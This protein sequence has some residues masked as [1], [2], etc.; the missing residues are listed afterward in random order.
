MKIDVL[1]NQVDDHN[2][3][4]ILATQKFNPN[5]V[6][7]I[8]SNE[9]ES[10][11]KSLREYYKNNFPKV[12]FKEVSVNEADDSKLKNIL[13]EHKSKKIIVNLTGGKRINSLILCNLCITNDIK[14]VYV[15]ILNKTLYT[16]DKDIEVL[17]EEFDDLEIEDVINASGGKIINHATT[18]CEKED[19]IYLTKCIY[20]NL[21]LW[22]NHKQKLY[23]ANIFYHDYGN[24]SRVV[25]KTKALDIKDKKMIEAILKKL[26][27]LNGIKY[28]S[29]EDE[30]IEVNF[31]NEY[32]KAFIFKSGTWLEMAT[33]IMIN[34]IKDVDEVKSGVIFLWN[35]DIRMIRNEVDVVAIKDS[36][37]ICISC[38]DSDK[39]N[40]TALN[41]LNVY[42]EKIGGEKVHKILVA[43]K[44]PIK[45]S[46]KE[47]AKEMNIHLIIFDGDEN[48]FKKHI[49]NIIK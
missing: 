31:L 21:P 17:K 20:K 3:G 27:E 42:S 36:V 34:E 26:K 40:E 44:E 49:Q 12:I 32:L 43:T 18:L 47:R 1:I 6:V 25:I 33:N 5:E 7:F 48:K 16:F 30:Q 15:D 14:S 4:N 8:K 37:P 11:L 41:E 2:Q 45:A 13:D 9:D 29:I 28:K 24:T 38:K 39:Y 10:I 19:L 46:V 23:D 35:D 22:H